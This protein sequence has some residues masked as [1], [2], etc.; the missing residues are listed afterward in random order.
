VHVPASHAWERKELP[1]RTLYYAGLGESGI[2]GFVISKVACGEEVVSS[3]RSS[4]RRSVAHVTAAR[5]LDFFS[6]ADRPQFIMVWMYCTIADAGRKASTCIQ[7]NK[8]YTLPSSSHSIVLKRRLPCYQVLE[9]SPKHLG[10]LAI[11]WCN[12]PTLRSKP[13]CTG[14]SGI[15][16]H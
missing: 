14:H 13:T 2:R 4:D 5:P 12:T 1:E 11:H 16:A 8:G 15:I 6:A 7:S 9:P 10:R 3:E